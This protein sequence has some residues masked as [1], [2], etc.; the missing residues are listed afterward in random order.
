MLTSI[1]S[2]ALVSAVAS[3]TTTDGTTSMTTAMGLPEYGVLAVI[4]LVTLLSAKLML[5]A[6]TRW[7][8]TIKCSLDM[9]II[10]LLIS[11]AAIVIYKIITII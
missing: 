1:A 9:N 7:N 10:P 2:A 6:S 8:S 11:F 3:V 4:A 5:S